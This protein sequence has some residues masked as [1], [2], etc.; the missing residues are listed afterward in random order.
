MAHKAAT[1]GF[2]RVGV[3]GG[4]GSGKTT[5]CNLFQSLGRHVIWADLLARSIADTDEGV[6][7]RIRAIFGENAY[8]ASGKL[9][10]A[11]IGAL[12]FSHPG[13]LEQLNAI[14][15]PAVFE[16]V[17]REILALP[18][19]NRY[20]YVVIEAALIFETGYDTRMDFTIVVEAAESLRLG[21]IM[22]RD[23]L[24]ATEIRRRMRSQMSPGEKAR[25]AD[26]VIGNEGSPEELLPRV[27]FLDKV[28]TAMAVSEGN[29]KT[30]QG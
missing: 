15:H 26:F 2:L 18:P 13:R 27:R 22:D 4:I 19:E 25:R 8:D 23:G 28:L 21:R 20:P 30:G 10:R 1:G 12:V 14:V 3:T 16:G 11:E 29:D 7:R 17:E 6:K 9:D 5:V 24:T